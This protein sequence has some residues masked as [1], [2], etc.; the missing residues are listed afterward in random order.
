MP[1]DRAPAQRL[2][3]ILRNIDAAREFTQG[4]RFEDFVAD[5]KTVYAVTRA[6]EIVSEASRH[7]PAEMKARMVGINWRGI[8][9][10]GN[11]YRHAYDAVGAVRV[12]GCGRASR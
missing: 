11:V 4:M 10:V 8:A 9:A 12:A 3:D 6:L 2:D 5:L 7:L 1:S